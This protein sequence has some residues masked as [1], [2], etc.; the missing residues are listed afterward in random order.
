MVFNLSVIQF[1]DLAIQFYFFIYN[2]IFLIDK[3]IITRQRAQG[4]R[5]YEVGSAKHEVRFVL[6]L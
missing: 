4:H 2:E 3:D 6:N 5:T 1:S